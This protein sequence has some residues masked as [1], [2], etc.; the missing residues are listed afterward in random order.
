[1]IPSSML[2]GERFDAQAPP[3]STNFAFQCQ[4]LPESD[5][6]PNLRDHG[7]GARSRLNPEAREFVSPSRTTSLSKGPVA[8][9]RAGE[10][11]SSGTVNESAVK[12]VQTDEIIREVPKAADDDTCETTLQD[13]KGPSAVTSQ[14][15]KRRRG[16]SEAVQKGTPRKEKGPAHQG[17]GKTP[18]K[19]SKRGKGKERAVTVSAKADKAEAKVKKVQEMPQT[20]ENQGGK[21]K[22][23]GLIDDDWPSLPASRERA[24]SKPQT[25]LIWGGKTKSTQ[26]DGGLEQGSPVTKN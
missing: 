23:P 11:P 5:D 18:A 10:A 17:E 20:P 8:N 3:P 24:Q 13:E 16:I 25:P 9:L 22:K 15:P 19:S 4:S 12:H 7:N 6:S 21:V 26:D 2:A 1:M 14:T